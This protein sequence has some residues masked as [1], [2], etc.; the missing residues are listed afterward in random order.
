MLN[1]GASVLVLEPNEMIMPF[2]SL[3]SFNLITSIYFM[4]LICL[5]LSL[6]DLTVH[7]PSHICILT[8]NANITEM[9]LKMVEACLHF[10]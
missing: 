6:R 5:M 8:Y 10:L 9:M 1:R 7:S 4:C 3:I 2:F